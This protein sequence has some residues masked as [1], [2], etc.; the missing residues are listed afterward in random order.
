[1][2][3]NNPIQTR[4]SLRNIAL[5]TV[6]TSLPPLGMALAEAIRGGG[7]PSQAFPD[8]INFWSTIAAGTAGIAMLSI[9][10]LYTQPSLIQPSSPT[11]PSLPILASNLR[12][13]PPPCVIPCVKN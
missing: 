6:L 8:S 5:A 4:N 10:E 1:M 12:I 7:N 3:N 13:P 9:R 2:H 11:P